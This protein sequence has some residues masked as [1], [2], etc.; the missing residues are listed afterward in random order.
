MA[1][2]SHHDPPGELPAHTGLLREEVLALRSVLGYTDFAGPYATLQSP[3][4]GTKLPDSSMKDVLLVAVDVDSNNRT[5]EA[6]P[7]QQLHIGVSLFDPRRLQKLLGEELPDT[8]RFQ[9]LIDSYQF[10]V[11]DSAYCQKATE[12]FLFGQSSPVLLSQIQTKLEEL[13]AGRDF[14]LVFHSAQWDLKTLNKIGVDVTALGPLYTFDT[15]KVAQWPLQLH[16]RLDLGK[17]CRALDIS[18][19]NLHAAGNDAHFTLRA[20][21]MLAVKDAKRLQMLHGC[22]NYTELLQLLRY[23]AQAPRPTSRAEMQQV[24]AEKKQERDARRQATRLAK[25]ERRRQRLRSKGVSEGDAA[26]SEG[27]AVGEPP[28]A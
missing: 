3:G 19:G 9:H 4:F 25:K 24:L 12:K 6:C 23:V 27:D 13:T 5:E 2:R 18:P 8:A 20:L 7:D 15:V 28:T 22:S 16:Y 1:P 14:A 11:G 21:L 17:L 10:T 26:A